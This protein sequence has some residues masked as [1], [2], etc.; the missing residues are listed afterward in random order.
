MFHGVSVAGAAQLSVSVYSQMKLRMLSIRFQGT[1]GALRSRIVGT[2]FAIGVVLSGIGWL[3]FV[4]FLLS[5]TG[6]VLVSI[7]A[8][9]S[10]Y[11][12][13]SWM[14]RSEQE[15]KTIFSFGVSVPLLVLPLIA[16]CLF[17][18]LGGILPTV[19]TEHFGTD[20]SFETV[21][22]KKV[23]TR[24]YTIRI[25][26]SAGLYA[27]NPNVDRWMWDQI[28]VGDRMIVTGKRTFLGIAIS[29]IKIKR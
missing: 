16:V 23:K 21:V 28:E 12:I 20:V 7:A 10:A 4:Q 29:E 6:A 11:V 17:P 18:L 3:L 26:E 25:P 14:L 5:V 2:L 8:A 24:A 13:L 1:G 19:Y 15:G 22:E 27:R 9:A